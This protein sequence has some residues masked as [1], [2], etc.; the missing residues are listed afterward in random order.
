ML[1]HVLNRSLEAR[2]RGQGV[3]EKNRI[4]P[5]DVTGKRGQ[6]SPAQGLQ[7]FGHQKLRSAPSRTQRYVLAGKT[8]LAGRLSAVDVLIKVNK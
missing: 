8:N 2:P 6:D 5:A 4:P 3:R 7:S 1:S